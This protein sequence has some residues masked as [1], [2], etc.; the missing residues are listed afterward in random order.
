MAAQQQKKVAATAAVNTGAKPVAAAPASEENIYEDLSALDTLLTV[1]LLNY[2]KILCE[3]YP[4]T[5]G[6]Q[7]YEYLHEARLAIS[8]LARKCNQLEYHNRRSELAPFVEERLHLFELLV[9]YSVAMDFKHTKPTQFMQEAHRLSRGF[10]QDALKNPSAGIFDYCA[11][12]VRDGKNTE[13]VKTMLYERDKFLT[14]SNLSLLTGGHPLMG[15]MSLFIRSSPRFLA[16][17]VNKA[18]TKTPVT[19][20]T[21]EWLLL[22]TTFAFQAYRKSWEQGGGGMTQL[23]CCLLSHAAWHSSPPTVDPNQLKAMV[24]FLLSAMVQCDTLEIFCRKYIDS[25]SEKSLNRRLGTFIRESLALLPTPVYLRPDLKHIS[26][27]VL[28]NCLGRVQTVGT[29]KASSA[30]H[31][32]M[33]D[34]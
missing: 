12:A 8:E 28:T 18:N 3:Q 32:I 11:A 20:N 29:E 21:K 1:A 34:L 9:E 7:Y 30:L 16:D 23:E 25:L 19:F 26:K 14:E 10:L 22:Y 27:L 17:R 24:D 6:Y 31:N 4:E 13:R 15:A 2:S 5:G 33:K